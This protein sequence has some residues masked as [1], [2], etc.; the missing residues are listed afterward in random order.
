MLQDER[1]LEHKNLM[2]KLS[3][4]V[5]ADVCFALKGYSANLTSVRKPKS[6]ARGLILQLH[7]PK[8]DQTSPDPL[9]GPVRKTGNIWGQLRWGS[10]EQPEQQLLPWVK[11]AEQGW[12]KSP[13]TSVLMW[14]P[15]ALLRGTYD[16]LIQ[17]SNTFF[18]KEWNILS[19]IRIQKHH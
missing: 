10:G 2:G 18:S 16:E 15:F 19:P 5:L 4:W 1:I 12:R 3:N 17:L 7:L 14:S 8:Q 9:L 6:T 11:D 13:P